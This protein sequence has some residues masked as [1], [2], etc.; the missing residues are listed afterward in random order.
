LLVL[1]LRI[2]AVV[3]R[4]FRRLFGRSH[5]GIRRRLFHVW[6]RLG[7]RDLGIIGDDRIDPG[8]GDQNRQRQ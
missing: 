6:C 1:G 3:G 4:S 8:P 5:F 7:Y 2:R